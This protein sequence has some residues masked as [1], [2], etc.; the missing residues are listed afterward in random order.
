MMVDFIPVAVNV[1]V[2]HT[3]LASL[4]PTIFAKCLKE[5]GAAGGIR[6]PDPRITNALLYQLSYCGRV[7]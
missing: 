7:R 5:H 4:G 3:D 1:A 6:T 2:S